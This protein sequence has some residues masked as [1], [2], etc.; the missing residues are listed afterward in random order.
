VSA[1]ISLVLVLVLIA[2]SA[3]ARDV[4]VNNQIGDDTFAGG[5]A[6][7][8]IDDGPVRTLAKALRLAVSGDHVVLANT[9][10]A[11]REPLS[12]MGGCHSGN[13]FGP[14]VVQGNGAILDGSMA[15]PPAAWERVK[16]DVFR[17]QP[18]LLH[19]QQLFLN[20]RPARRRPIDPARPTP[21]LLDPLEWSLHE[22]HIYFRVETRRSPYDYNLSCAGFPVGVTMYR[23]HDVVIT[24]LIVQG[25]QIDGLSAPDDA[26]NCT[27]L[28]V[29]SRGNGRS[30]VAAGG[31]SRLTL[32]GCTVGDNGVSQLFT[33]GMAEILLRNTRLL[34]KSAPNILSD[35]GQVIR[36]ASE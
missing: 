26:H 8:T 35:G 5:S 2:S 15:I 29:T 11:Y 7:P 33:S 4:F 18:R 16:G 24:D 34:P 25:F 17:F 36:A 23:V 21:T 12:L 9:G 14:F 22:G 31:T 13:Y 30:G 19:F 27:L 32:E 6:Q 3:V 1:R 28:N 10:E 20:D